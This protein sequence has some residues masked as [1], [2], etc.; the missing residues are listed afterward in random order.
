[1]EL[2]QIDFALVGDAR[3]DEARLQIDA[4]RDR[5]IERDR[6][7]IPD[8]QRV[9]IPQADPPRTGKEQCSQHPAGVEPGEL[10]PLRRD[11]DFA[12]RRE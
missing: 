1:M 10:N 12:R 3:R 2:L 9:Q 4:S 7:D 5:E 6:P 11:D 8:F